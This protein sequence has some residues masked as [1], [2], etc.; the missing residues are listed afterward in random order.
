MKD[1]K[2]N[3]AIEFAKDTNNLFTNQYGSKLSRSL[4]LTGASTTASMFI[5]IGKFI[6]GVLALSFLTCANALYT[7]GMVVAKIVAIV[8]IRKAQT[9]KDQYPY[10][11]WSG[12]ILIVSS[13]VYIVYSIQLFFNPISSSYH[14]Y[15]GIGIATVTFTEVGLNIRGVIL[16]RHNH[17][18]LF[19][20]I[21][22]INLSA[23][24]IALVLTQTA[25]LSFTEIESDVLEIAKAN[26][27]IGIMMGILATVIGIYMICRIVKLKKR[28]L[29]Q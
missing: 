18:L 5:A 2:L 24:F 29:V 9:E 22:M 28:A 23:S 8:G 20:A 4:S 25:L 15:V 19:H 14:M 11:L 3:K 26:G 16:T 7:L 21:K 1:K 27:A 12:A 6:L 13:L 17:T 10:Y